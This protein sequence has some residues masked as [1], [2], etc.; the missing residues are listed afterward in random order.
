MP[1]VHGGFNHHYMNNP[2]FGNGHYG[3]PHKYGYV[4][5][6]AHGWGNQ[7]Y[8]LSA[9]ERESWEVQ[10]KYISEFGQGNEKYAPKQEVIIKDHEN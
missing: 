4:P 9:K 8:P 6:G 3:N 1:F 10:Q 5:N 2:Y 7:P